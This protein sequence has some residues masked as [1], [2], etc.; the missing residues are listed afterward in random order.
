MSEAHAGIVCYIEQL[1][2][3]F[4]DS[5]Q[6]TEMIRNAL[7]RTLPVRVDALLSTK[8]A[9][10]SKLS[11]GW[12]LLTRDECVLSHEQE[13][14]TTMTPQPQKKGLS[15]YLAREL[16]RMHDSLQTQLDLLSQE[17]QSDR[18]DDATFENESSVEF[19]PLPPNSKWAR[20]QG[21]DEG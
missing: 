19:A 10:D 6:E 12:V 15:A 16:V 14:M 13:L 8:A 11:V 4:G 1:Q 5:A 20:A 7:R 17:V 18:N 2:A 3:V 9:F 21:G